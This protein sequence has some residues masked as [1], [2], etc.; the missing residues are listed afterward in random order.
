MRHRASV[1]RVKFFTS[2]IWLIHSPKVKGQKYIGFRGLNKMFCLHFQ[3]NFSKNLFTF[4]RK[5]S[6]KIHVNFRYF[7]KVF[8]IFI[9][10]LDISNFFAKISSEMEIF[11]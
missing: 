6:A 2:F 8:S 11:A 7:C 3:G 10:K 5:L 9:T 1:A 4:F